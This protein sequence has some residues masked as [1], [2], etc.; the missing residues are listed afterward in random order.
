MQEAFKQRNCCMGV[1]C[2]LLRETLRWKKKQKAQ[3]TTVYLTIIRIKIES[4]PFLLERKQFV[5]YLSPVG[6][7]LPARKFIIEVSASIKAVSLGTVA[8]LDIQ[9]QLGWD[10]LFGGITLVVGV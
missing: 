7:F 1:K 9:K 8:M 2:H 10:S 5:L 4:T 3:L 6:V